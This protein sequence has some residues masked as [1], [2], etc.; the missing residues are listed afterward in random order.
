M[1]VC[2]QT[3]V[4][5]PNLN[6]PLDRCE[7]GPGD[8]KP[9]NWWGNDVLPPPS[10]RRDY[11]K[12]KRMINNDSNNGGGGGGSKVEKEML[13]IQARLARLKDKRIEEVIN[14][15]IVSF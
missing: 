1:L 2:F 15:R 8:P 13:D 7:R 3:H 9:Q 5:G 6:K 11:I 14:P 12:P 10:M 4:P